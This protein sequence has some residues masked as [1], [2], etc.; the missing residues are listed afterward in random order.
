MYM[1]AKGFAGSEDD[2]HMASDWRSG[3][4][5]TTILLNASARSNPATSKESLEAILKDEILRA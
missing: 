4:E 1:R 2:G 3:V 5:G